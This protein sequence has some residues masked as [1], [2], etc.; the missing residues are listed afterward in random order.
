MFGKTIFIRFDIDTVTCMEK[1]VPLLLHLARVLGIKFTFFVNYG[2][3]IDHGEILLRTFGRT[4]KNV[5]GSGCKISILRKLGI[6]DTVRTFLLNPCVGESRDEYIHRMLDEGHEVGLHGGHNHSIWQ[7]RAHSAAREEIENWL[8][9]THEKFRNRFGLP[10]GF[11]SPGGNGSPHAYQILK[12]LGYRYVSDTMKEK[13]TLP[14]FE[15]HGL[16]QI[17]VNGQIDQIPLMEHFRAKGLPEEVIVENALQH[18]KECPVKTLVA[19]PVWE[20]YRDIALFKKMVVRLLQEGYG[21]ACFKDIYDHVT[22]ASPQ[23]AA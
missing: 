1:G 6:T 20:G 16:L 22:Q 11:A 2:K 21:F 3:S 4:L 9:H 5:T 10:A 7:R 18:I 15:Q 13:D 14:S 8:L 17:P 23:G 12:D 19:H